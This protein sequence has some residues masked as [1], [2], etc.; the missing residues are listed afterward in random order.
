MF[1]IWTTFAAK[2][3]SRWVH[4]FIEDKLTLL[5]EVAATEWLPPNIA[6]QRGVLMVNSEE[7]DE[8]QYAA[9]D[10]FDLFA[11]NWVARCAGKPA[12]PVV[13]SPRVF[14]EVIGRLRRHGDEQKTRTD[15]LVPVDVSWE[16][17]EKAI[18]NSDVTQVP[19]IVDFL[20]HKSIE[21]NASDL[22]V[23]PG[24]DV[25]ITRVRVDG[26]LQELMAAA[27]LI[28]RPIG[29]ADQDPGRHGCGGTAPASRRT[30]QRGDP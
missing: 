30:D 15:Y 17:T 24:D 5:N 29:I 21:H 27:L 12:R 4:G 18:G 6:L 1:P 7:T 20:L 8:V 22:H 11:K 26:L 9:Y 3:P 25:M 16:K 13:V 23:E 2:Q 14:L 28:A 19:A 10:P